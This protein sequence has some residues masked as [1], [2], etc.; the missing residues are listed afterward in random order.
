MWQILE[1]SISKTSLF[2]PDF[3]FFLNWPIL[4]TRHETLSN[5]VLSVFSML[6]KYVRL[7][8]QP[9]SKLVYYS[10]FKG[11]FYL[12]KGLCSSRLRSN[13]SLAQWWWYTTIM[14]ATWEVRQEV[15]SSRQAYLKLK[16]KKQKSFG[17]VPQWLIT[18]LACA[19]SCVHSPAVGEK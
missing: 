17:T 8:P 2:C 6:S 1:S 4:H 15:P 18:G 5:L 14:P 3:R 13:S 11:S 16:F 7:T 19:R 10:N 12:L 9:D